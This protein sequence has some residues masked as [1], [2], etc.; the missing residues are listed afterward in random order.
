M[1]VAPVGPAVQYDASQIMINKQQPSKEFYPQG[2]GP[3]QGAPGYNQIPLNASSLQLSQIASSSSNQSQMMGQQ[4]LLTIS[5]GVKPFTPSQSIY[6]PNAANR[7]SQAN[8]QHGGP[9]HRG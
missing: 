8:N 6:A 9:A 5:A 3:L 4:S 2:A 1:M 7:S